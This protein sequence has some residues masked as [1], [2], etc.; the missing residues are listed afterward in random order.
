MPHL[1]VEFPRQKMPARGTARVAGLGLNHAGG[2]D[3]SQQTMPR[4]GVKVIQ[5]R[6][7]RGGVFPALRDG[8]TNM[9]EMRLSRFGMGPTEGRHSRPVVAG[10]DPNFSAFF[11]RRS[12]NRMCCCSLMY[13][14]GRLTPRKWT[15]VH[16]LVSERGRRACAG[17]GRR[18]FCRRSTRRIRSLLICCRSWGE[19]RARLAYLAWRAARAYVFVP[20]VLPARRVGCAAVD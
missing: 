13:Q 1:T 19:E 20:T 6:T 16:Q 14:R 11:R 5:Q 12:C 17:G 2:G 7:P 8:T 15:A 18:A 4:G 9:F 10:A 3:G